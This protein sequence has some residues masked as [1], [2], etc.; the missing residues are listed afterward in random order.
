M[1]NYLKCN[2]FSRVVL[3]FL[4]VNNKL[5]KLS[6]LEEDFCEWIKLS[7]AYRRMQKIFEK[8][9]NNSHIDEIYIKRIRTKIYDTY[10]IINKILF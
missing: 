1:C 3:L 4:N 5:E 7:I 8:Y 10:K 9:W 6:D 2:Y